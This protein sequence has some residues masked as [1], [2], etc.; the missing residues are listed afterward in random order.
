MKT[1]T[2]N[3]LKKVL[4][5]TLA[6]EKA[7]E[8]LREE[9]SHNLGPI[10]VTDVKLERLAENVNDR[11]DVLERTGRDGNFGFK[12]STLLRFAEHNSPEVRRL[13]AR[14]LPERFAEKFV[15][16][17]DP[18]VRHAAARKVPLS[19]L[20]EMLRRNPSDDELH[21]I[22]RGR[23]LKEGADEKSIGERLKGVVKVP[24]APELSNFAYQNLAKTAIRD[25]NTNIEGQWDEP[26]V[27]RYC[28]SMKATSGIQYDAKKLWEE[29]QKQLKEKDERTL[30]RFSL[31]EVASRLFEG[32]DFEDVHEVADPIEELLESSLSA[33][34]FVNRV[35]TLFKIRESIMPAGLRK[36]RVSEGRISEMSIPCTGKL[37]S[38]TRMCSR[39]ER[40]LDLYASNWNDIQ[41]RR[42]EPIKINWTPNT[43]S[44]GSF[45][46]NVELK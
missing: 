25:Y 19:T 34:E 6:E 8:L 21:I 17:R 40:V 43:M 10:V 41:A 32:E 38:G 16:D 42:G 28:A 7:V 2:V 37:P 12:P 20:K 23:F 29:I 45:S 44:I 35:N 31:K 22:Y 9:V 30:E 4:K 26:W 11:I 24:A 13:A 3:E 15:L 33:H 27:A 46:F 39:T 36:Y 14:L 18:A 1:I 5:Q